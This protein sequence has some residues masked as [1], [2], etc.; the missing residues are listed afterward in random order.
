MEMTRLVKQAA[1]PK[2][3]SELAISKADNIGD[4]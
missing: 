1:I 2:D 4:L 3:F